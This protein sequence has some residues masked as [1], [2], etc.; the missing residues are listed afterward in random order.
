MTV[1]RLKIPVSMLSPDVDPAQLGFDDTSEL[2][3]LNEIIGQERAVEALEFGLHMKSPGFNLY[4][5]GPVGTGKG[6]LVRNMVKR[7]AQGT[8][9]PADW[10]YVNN[11]QDTSRP[12][13]LSFPAGQGCIFKREMTAFIESLR[14]DIPLAFDSKKYLD[15]KA[16]IIDD[17][18]SKKKALFQD[19][20]KLSGADR[21]SVV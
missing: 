9:A 14:R 18:E 11:F 8:P 20:T 13:C 15:A 3:P 16:K 21:K 5:S 4:V 17:A 19:L 7:M 2:E 6:T 10:C 1:D 12:V